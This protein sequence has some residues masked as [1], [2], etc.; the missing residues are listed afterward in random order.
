MSNEIPQNDRSLAYENFIERQKRILSTHKDLSLTLNRL[1]AACVK[2][3]NSLIGSAQLKSYTARRDEV[4]SKFREIPRTF[5]ST[6]EG[7]REE[8]DYRQK[9]VKKGQQFVAGLN[10]DKKE[11]EG[12]FKGYIKKAGTA[13]NQHLRPKEEAPYVITDPAM[14]PKQTHNPWTFKF[15]PYD[16]KWGYGYGSGT[17]GQPW[18]DH[19]ESPFTSQIR[20]EGGFYI[21]DSGDSDWAA[22]HELSEVWVW[23]KMPVTGLV[24]AWLYLQSID[25]YYLGGM[26]DE[27]GISD[28]DVMQWSFP[29]MEVFHPQGERR[30]GTL[31]DFEI[32]E[33]DCS[34]SGHIANAYAGDF[35]YVHLFSKEPYVEGVWVL[36]AFG[37][38]DGNFAWVNDYTCW[39]YMR[40]NWLLHHLAIRSTGAP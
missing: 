22:T 26:D 2:D 30:W 24:E 37:I 3:V 38:D 12:V 16:G 34:W 17:A 23:Y 19:Y 4:R 32:G 39:T 5:K 13:V 8:Q 18:A 9:L 31:L 15:P 21:Q 36:I 14:V 28:I 1:S 25:T 11:V 33:N 10:I 29:Y 27:W 7:K 35:R 20:T 40:N 6:T